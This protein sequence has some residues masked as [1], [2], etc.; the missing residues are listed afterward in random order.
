MVGPTTSEKQQ[1]QW[2]YDEI[3]ISQE[4][5]NA[6]KDLGWHWTHTSSLNMRRRANKYAVASLIINDLSFEDRGLPGNV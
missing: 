6:R 1:V 2:S 4:E 5:K 3:S